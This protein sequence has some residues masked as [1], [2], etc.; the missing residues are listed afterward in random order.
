MQNTD[1]LLFFKRL[2]VLRVE[3]RL[4]AVSKPPS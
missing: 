3:C 1:L 4:A 2:A